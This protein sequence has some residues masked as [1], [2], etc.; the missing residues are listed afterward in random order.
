MDFEP[1][2]EQQMLIDQVR[3]FVREKC[4]PIEAKVGEE[5]RVPDA[6]IAEMRELGL[7]GI[8]IPTEYGGLG[9]SM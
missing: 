7:F 1:N 2:S 5:D 3:R 8:S 6:I 9:L 4:V